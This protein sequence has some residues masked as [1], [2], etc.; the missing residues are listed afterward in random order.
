MEQAEIAEDADELSV[1]DSVS[2]RTW[3]FHKDILYS[4]IKAEKWNRV[5][6]GTFSKI[7]TELHRLSACGLLSI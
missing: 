4:F 1:S 3:N 7:G 5:L 2:L 6:N